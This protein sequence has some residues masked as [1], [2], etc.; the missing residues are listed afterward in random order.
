MG[1][2][3]P[4]LLI[5]T[6]HISIACKNDKSELVNDAILTKMQLEKSLKVASK[7]YLKAWSEN[8]STLLKETTIR[9]IVRNVNGE[10]V[11]SNQKGL[12]NAIRFWHVALPDF[13]MI[14][15]EI[16]VV[17]N[18]T[19]IHW[20]S[21]GTNTGMYGKMTPTGKKCSTEGFSIL[22]FDESRQLIHVNA[23]YDLLGVMKN[24]GYMLQ[25]PNTD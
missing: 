23:Y 8:D 22:T 14:D 15:K 19:F 25:P 12:Y 5:I 6:L 4:Y 11:S 3:L 24:M 20:R 13:K 17:G 18:R 2:Y 1:K 21:T 10:I 16:N 7:I 9:N